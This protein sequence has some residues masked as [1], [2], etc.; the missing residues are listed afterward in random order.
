VSYTRPDVGTPL[1]QAE[2]DAATDD[3]IALIKQTRYFDV[4]DERVHGWPESAGGYWYG[5]WW[6]GIT[7][8]KANGVVTYTHSQDGSD[9]NGLRTAPLL[10]AACYAYLIRGDALT[11]NL[12][13][14]MV[15]GYSSWSLAMVRTAGDTLK[16][17]LARAHYAANVTSTDGGRSIVLDFSQDRP[18]VD[19]TSEYVHLPTNPTFGDIWIKN[20][21]SKDDMGHVYR[22]IAQVQACAPRLDAAGQADVKQMNDLYVAWAKQVEAD[23][24][25]IA[26]VDKNAQPIMPPPSVELAHY[27]LVGNIECPGALMLRLFGDGDPGSLSCGSGVSPAEVIAGT[28]ITNSAK[29]IL[30]TSHE[31][32]VVTAWL[33]GQSSTGLALLQGL[34]QR[35]ESDLAAVTQA[36]PPSNVNPSDVAALLIHAS[37]AGVPLTSNEI[38][39]LHGRLHTA[40]Q[41]YITSTATPTYHLFDAQT[42]DGT[43][44][45]EPSGDGLA[46]NDIGV[47][48]GACAAPYRNPQGRA[49][50]DCGKLVGSL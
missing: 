22:S 35:V 42:P 37:N 28:N 7:V 15:R 21:R 5:T 20:N 46:W 18:G 12:V 36:N 10:E 24:W 38:R 8:T 14:R 49:I 39:W 27:Y 16:P 48:L 45:Y 26:T 30:R 1:T 43:Y 40:V 9:N 25:G 23:G 47:L 2:L 31:A 33:S 19:G 17:M 32:S 11:A 4:L 13:R 41:T 34:A 50:L 44:P 29:Q 6:S 3:L